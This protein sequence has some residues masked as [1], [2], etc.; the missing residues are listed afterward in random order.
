[1]SPKPTLFWRAA[2]VLVST[3]RTVVA[4]LLPAWLLSKSSNN[5]RPSSMADPIRQLAGQIRPMWEQMASKRAM[6]RTMGKECV[7]AFASKLAAATRL[8]EAATATATEQVR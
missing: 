2:E 6:V 1:M 4:A 3:S 5:E 8:L 7:G